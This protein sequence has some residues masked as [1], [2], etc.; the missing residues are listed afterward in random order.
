MKINRAFLFTLATVAIPLVF[1]FIYIRFVS[2]NVDKEIYGNF[3]LLQTL[4]SALSMIFLQIP[5]QAYDRFYNNAVNKIE[6]INEF[7]T[8]LVFI[9]ITALLLIIIY[10]NIMKKFDIEVLILLFLYFILLN[11]Y[12]FNQKVFLLNLE[13]EKYFIL[14]VSESVAKFFTPLLL[15]FYF[16]TLTSFIGGVVIGYFISFIFLLKYMKN[17]PFKININWGNYK[18]YLSYAYP[19]FFVATFSWGISFS[20]RYFIDYLSG[21]K[22]V[23]IYAILAQVAGIGQIIGQVYIMYVNPKVLKLYE[24]KRE[25]ALVYLKNSLQIM[26]LIFLLLGLLI[27][28]IPVEIY[29]LLLEKTLITK[30]YYFN[31]FY[32]LILGIFFTVFQTALSMYLQ[33]FKKLFILGYIYLIAFIVNIIGNLYIKDYGIIAA[34][35]ATLLAYIIIFI[36]QF[37]YIMKHEGK[38]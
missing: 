24:Q 16:E 11:N 18:K 20:D 8:V 31:T 32:I 25:E 3:V 35:I 17:Y 1:Q 28:F 2:Y 10:G 38:I 14:K 9:N 34:A 30:E 23:A 12:S 26:A 29:S 19:I 5:S 21:T 22:D 4:I 36:L 7:R 37:L 6:F 33:L 15:Y 13:R 27:Y